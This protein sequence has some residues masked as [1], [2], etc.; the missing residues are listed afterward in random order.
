MSTQKTASL[1]AKKS[2]DLA[3]LK[4]KILNVFLVDAKDKE[5]ITEKDF[6]EVLEELI[7]DLG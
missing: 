2:R 7:E 6:L 5:T 4:I 3:G 1:A